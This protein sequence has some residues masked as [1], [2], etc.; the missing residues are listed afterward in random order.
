MQ[1]L[2]QITFGEKSDH[3]SFHYGTL[4][5]KNLY[6]EYNSILKWYKYTNSLTRGV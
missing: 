4:W 5:Q 1:I 3:F 2:C 6:S